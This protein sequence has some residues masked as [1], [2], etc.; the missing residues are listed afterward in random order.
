MEGFVR[1]GSNAVGFLV[2]PTDMN[3]SKVAACDC[4]YEITMIA[5]ASAGPTMVTVYRRWD[6][7]GGNPIDPVEVGTATVIVPCPE[8]PPQT[9]EEE[10]P[11]PAG[12]TEGR[13]TTCEPRTSTSWPTP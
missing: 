7:V 10:N 9:C 2:Q 8:G 6:H 3:P 13:I 11:D 12:V 5:D 4:L 1:T